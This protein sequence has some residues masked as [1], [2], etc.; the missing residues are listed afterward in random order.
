MSQDHLGLFDATPTPRQIR[1]GWIMIE[2][3]VAAMFAVLAIPDIQLVELNA[4]IPVIDSI[5][6]LGDLVTATFL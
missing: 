3:L 4:V 1:L 6:L 5:M 2:L